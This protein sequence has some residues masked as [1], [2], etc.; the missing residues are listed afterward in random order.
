VKVEG[1]SDVG[2]LL[3]ETINQ[4]RRGEIDPRVANEVESSWATVGLDF[5]GM[6]R[7]TGLSI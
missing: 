6:R 4:I 5:A 1:G 2:K 7:F 3:S